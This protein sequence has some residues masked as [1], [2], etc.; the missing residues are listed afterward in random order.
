LNIPAALSARSFAESSSVPGLNFGADTTWRCTCAPTL[1]TTPCTSQACA[2][3][4]SF[5]SLEAARFAC[6]M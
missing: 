1:R 2:R 6:A 5:S 4:S 3:F